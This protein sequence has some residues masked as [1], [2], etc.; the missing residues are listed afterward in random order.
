MSR[1]GLVLA[2][3][4]GTRLAPLTTAVSKQLLP[5]YNKPMIHYP[6]STLLKANI[7][8]I[9][10]IVK[11]DEDLNLFK[12][13]LEP[14]EDQGIYLDYEVQEEPNGIAEAFLIA[15]EWLEGESVCL[16]LGDNVF[17]G[18]QF[19][20]MLPHVNE[21]QNVIFGCSVGNPEQYGVAFFDVKGK[22]SK[23]VEKPTE[24]TSNYAVPGL[25]FY[26]NSVVERA[27]K[28]RPSERG[29]LEITDLNNSYIQDNKLSLIKLPPGTVWFDCGTHQDLLEAG[30][31]V[32]AVEKRTGRNLAF[33]IRYY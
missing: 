17:V 2:G 16:I 8:D 22:V 15:E 13:H 24:S 21:D 20:V 1:K 29:E 25:Y 12:D 31:F 11:C 33:P 14:L 5:V 23:I 9:L 26:D 7:Q 28:L 19:D 32:Q 30:N 3:G 10:V 18:H 6:I 4:L 27:K